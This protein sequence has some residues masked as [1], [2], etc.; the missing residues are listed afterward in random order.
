M[1]ISDNKRLQAQVE[2]DRAYFTDQET[3]DLI[4]GDRIQVLQPQLDRLRLLRAARVGFAAMYKAFL[5]TDGKA[6]NSGRMATM[7]T[8]S[9]TLSVAY[10]ETSKAWFAEVKFGFPSEIKGDV[11]GVPL[12]K[13][14]AIQL[15]I[16]PVH[17]RDT[18]DETDEHHDDK[19]YETVDAL[20]KD[21]SAGD[22]LPIYTFTQAPA[23]ADRASTDTAIWTPY[24]M[25]EDPLVVAALIRQIHINLP[26]PAGE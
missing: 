13:V 2:L 3:N 21:M 9:G 24:Q 26:N 14:R 12:T 7:N 6:F 5:Q 11:S 22:L 18:A 25:T 20:Y 1:F 17:S 10:P 15:S 4:A 23:S 8:N 16:E 19:L